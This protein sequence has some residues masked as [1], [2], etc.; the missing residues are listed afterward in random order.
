[1]LKNKMFWLFAGGLVFYL[2]TTDKPLVYMSLPWREILAAGVVVGLFVLIM[3]F[4]HRRA[5]RKEELAQRALAV[6]QAHRP[7]Y[8]QPPIM[9]IPSGHFDRLSDR[10]PQVGPTPARWLDLPADKFEL[11]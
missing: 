3:V 10:G 6:R 7:R 11:L 1:M 8:M 9:V 2:Y 4:L 5:V